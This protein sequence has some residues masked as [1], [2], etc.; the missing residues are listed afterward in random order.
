MK[1]L[2]IITAVAV[3][4]MGNS[5]FAADPGEGRDGRY[6]FP[7]ALSKE[8]KTTYNAWV[9]Y[10]E[11]PTGKMPGPDDYEGWLKKRQEKN[12]IPVMLELNKQVTKDYNANVKE[13][14]IEGVRVL[15]ITPKE[16]TSP[17][18]V[19]IYAH[20]GGMYAQT[21]DILLIDAVPLATDAKVKI[22]SVDYRKIPGPPKGLTVDDQMDDIIKVYKH[23]V[24]EMEYDRKKVGWYSCSA[25]ST[26][27]M[28]AMNI[29]S[30]EGYPL[31]GAF[32]PNAGPYDW[33][34]SGD[35]WY[36][37][38]GFDPIVSGVHYIDPLV[39]MMKIDPK[40]PKYSPALDDFKGREWPPTMLFSGGREMLLSDSIIMNQKLKAADHDSE[41]MVFDGAP[42]CW[43]NVYQAPES[44]EFRRLWTK[45]MT[46]KGV[47]TGK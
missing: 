44:K 39:A 26:I 12:T 14:F 37:M 32:A 38:E 22:L 47:L 9:P 23:V 24:E 31:P 2:T 16:V 28:G 18:S 43:P 7:N 17:D 30:H 35:T 34:K 4:L 20:P 19:I 11:T 36:T 33:S 13:A 5:T 46:E 3:F 40:D 29:L 41:L 25:G 27:T 21:A 15:E 6:K 45:F 1:L 8:V 10:W 42:H